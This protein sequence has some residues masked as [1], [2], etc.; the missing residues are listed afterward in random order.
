MSE[1]RLSVTGDKGYSMARAT[2]GE[3]N[4]LHRKREN[5]W[6]FFFDATLFVV[7]VNRGNWFFEVSDELETL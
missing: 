6:N 4:L 7:G 1:D 3:W 2:H 5:R